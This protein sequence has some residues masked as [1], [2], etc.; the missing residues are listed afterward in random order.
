[1][2]GR[3]GGACGHPGVRR[4]PTAR[5]GRN[6]GDGRGRG[7]ASRSEGGG[8]GRF[9]KGVGCRLLK[10]A[11]GFSSGSRG[12]ATFA[13][14]TSSFSIVLQSPAAFWMAATRF[15]SSA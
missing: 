9:L 7:T 1:M 14:S 11:H 8:R 15:F 2:A 10:G 5:G 4:G 6:C 3:L 13:L 12:S